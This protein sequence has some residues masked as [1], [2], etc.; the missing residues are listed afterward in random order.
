M[1]TLA[2]PAG[3]PEKRLLVVD[4]DASC[5][6]L[7]RAIFNAEG[8][9]VL[10]AEDTRSGLERAEKE[11]P[12]VVLLDLLM[13]D[14]DG[15]SALERLKATGADCAVLMLTAEHD[16]KAAVAATRLGA[17]DYLTKPVDQEEVL[18]SVRHALEAR[19][20]RREVQRLRQRLSDGPTLEALMGASS[21]VE[22][23]AERVATVAPTRFTVLVLGETGTG[24]ELVAQA[25]HRQSDRREAPFIAL[26]CGA[27]PEPLLESELFG[28][29]KGSFT[30]ADRKKQGR[31][32]LAQGGTLFLDEVGNLPLGLQAKLLRVLESQEVAPVGGARATPL[33]VRFVAATNDD[34]EAR[35]QE[36]RFRADL[37]FRLAQYTLR[38]TPL[39]DRPE[40]IPYLATRFATEASVELRR[41]VLEIAP[42][43]LAWLQRRPWPGNVRELRNSV[44]QAVLSSREMVIRRDAFK[45][46]PGTADRPSRGTLPPGA[47]G[48]SLRDVAAAAVREAERAAISGALR[49]A[50]GNKSRAARALQTDYKTLH[51]KMKALGIRARDF[52]D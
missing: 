43:A 24:K 25:L 5:R 36:G 21:A 50:R 8:F 22:R 48:A 9:E 42:D 2:R 23:L 41:P 14:G 45:A 40:D 19:N 44:R 33:D 10:E 11:A 52:S 35:V 30:G 13:P 29:E 31:F 17:Y 32:Q 1:S 18:S 47:P 7:I 39:R 12:D 26:D 28:Y 27:I 38:L 6:R 16:V 46:A 49:D 34:L 15:L 51:L 4:D 3:A 37:Y 20:L